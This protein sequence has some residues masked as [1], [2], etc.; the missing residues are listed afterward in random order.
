MEPPD[1]D[2]A[3]GRL[4][5]APPTELVSLLEAVLEPLEARDVGLYLSDFQGIVLQPLPGEAFD[6]KESEDVAGSMAGRAYRT[7]SPVVAHRDD[8]VRVWVPLLERSERTG[9][10]AMT[11][12][13]DTDDVVGHCL[14]VAQFAGLIVRGFARTTDLVHLHR[15]RKSMTLAA[16]MQ[17]DLL[18]PL[19]IRSQRAL[20]CG[21]LEPAYEI[22]GDAFDYALNEAHLHAGLFDGMGHGVHST[23]MTT[24]AVGAYRHARRSDSPLSV[25]HAEIDEAIAAHYGGDAF[26]TSAMARLDLAEGAVEWSTAGH[27]APLLL[28]NRTV[29]RRLSCV[30]SLPLG[31]GGECREVAVEQLEPGDCLLIFT[32]GVVEGRSA[33]SDEEFGVA[34]LAERLEHHAASD[35]PADEILRQLIEDVMEHSDH[36]LR[37]DASLMLVRWLG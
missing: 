14:A 25:M 29:V 27:P 36:H 23:L 15:R 22:A 12:P 20:A 18:P 31:L 35:Q 3:L 4:A 24:L 13:T 28:R 10:L 2:A 9:V 30:P 5:E 6:E 19:T 34:R 37:D 32:D 17:W 11:V 16:G 33:T 1:Y 7:G 21:R 8:G 26:V